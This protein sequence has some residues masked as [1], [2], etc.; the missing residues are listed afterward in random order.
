[1]GQWVV[2][3]DRLRIGR[4]H[5]DDCNPG[6]IE[7]FSHYTRKR[8]SLGENATEFAGRVGNEYT[9]DVLLAKDCECFRHG[10]RA[11][12]Q[13]SLRRTQLL[14]AVITQA[15]ADLALGLSG[16]GLLVDQARQCSHSAAPGRFV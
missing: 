12:D 7:L 9:A 10:C 2:P 16:R 5:I 6:R 11:E 4:H 14:N 3:L 15:E 13:N 1:M 8:V